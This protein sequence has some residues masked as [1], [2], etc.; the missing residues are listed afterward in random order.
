[1][2]REKY[3]KI[4][5][6]SHNL[7]EDSNNIGKTLISLLKGWPKD[8]LA[9]LYFRNDMP[10]F[11]YCKSYYC[12]TDKEIVKSVCSFGIKKAGNKISSGNKL[13]LS[14][15]EMN[16]Y[17]V[18]NHRKPM[19]SLIR[20]ILWGFGGWKSDSLSKW[21]SEEVNPDIILFVPNDYCLAYRIALYI[22]KYTKKPIIPFYMDDAF[23]YGCKMSLVDR[24]RR[25]KLRQ[26]ARKL[27]MNCNRI[28]T[29]C[30]YMSREY[31]KKFQL[32]CNSFVNSVTFEE[33]CDCDSYPRKNNMIFAYLGNLHSNRW[34]SLVEIG[35]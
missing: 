23:Y 25:L 35:E 8:R 3:P 6:I 22:E 32:P 7:Y 14:T 30:D 16:L 13:N 2:S 20:D 19:I 24:V 21:I 1:M 29:I 26:M 34:K 28:F 11:K 18:G 17:Q 9:Q 10:S 5:I 12:I 33:M 31:E 15:T 27:H 4:L